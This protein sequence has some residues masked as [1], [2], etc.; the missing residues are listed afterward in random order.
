MTNPVRELRLV[1]TVEDFDRAIAFWRDTLGLE[2]Q[3]AV[4]S[5][6]GRV[7]ILKAGVATLEIADRNQAGFIDGIE[8]GRCV[9]GQFR[10][11]LR[12]DDVPAATEVFEA[13]GAK[14][15]GAPRPTPFRSTNSRLEAPDGVQLTLFDA[16]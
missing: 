9:S 16:E 11:A 6:D 7:A 14:L 4:S 15:L 1:I 13:A 3:L 10:V 2:E 8:V 5:E 12:V